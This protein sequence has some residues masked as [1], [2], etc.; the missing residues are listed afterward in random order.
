MNRLENVPSTSKADPM[1]P[2]LIGLNDGKAGMKGLDKEKINAIIEE[3]SRNSPFY[4]H[5]QRKEARI[6][7]Q[8]DKMLRKWA[9]VT[10][11]QK[12]A[13]LRIMMRD[14]VEYEKRAKDL[15]QIICHVDMDMFFAA[16][17]MKDQPHLREKPIAVGSMSMI[18]T[19]NYVAR[20][21]G[22]RAAMAG[23]IAKKLCPDLILI[24]CNFQKYSKES[25]KIMSVLRQYDPNILIMSCDEA[26]L[27]LTSYVVESFLTKPENK[28]KI[29]L[30]ENEWTNEKI[31][32][33]EVW[34]HASIIVEEMRGRVFQSSQLTCSA[35]IS[36]NTMLAKIASDMNKPD[37]QFM[38]P[39]LSYDQIQEFVSKIDV[40]KIPGIGP[41]QEKVLKAFN[42][43]TC[44]DLWDHRD[45]IYIL[46]ENKPS[47]INFYLRVSLGLG[48]SSTAKEEEEP[49]KSKGTENTFKPT[50][51]FT[52]LCNELRDMSQEISDSLNDYGLKGKTIT[53][54]LKKDSFDVI[55]KSRSLQTVTADANV[56]FQ[57]A[58]NIL[59][60]EIET[61][62]D[63]YRL[64]GVR[65]SHLIEP[66]KD[67]KE[68]SQQ[69]TLDKFFSKNSLV[70]QPKRQKVEEPKCSPISMM[71]VKDEENKDIEVMDDFFNETDSEE[72]ICPCGNSFEEYKTFETHMENCPNTSYS[73]NRDENQMECPVCKAKYFSKLDE[74]NSHLDEC[75]KMFGT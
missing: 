1:K 45:L 55:V 62:N 10:E 11:S 67:Q 12:E 53:L 16:V 28:N 40:R 33:P 21:Y 41:V 75:L 44:K 35:G 23:F 26:Y 29:V 34:D 64:M 52:W 3:A 61:T 13:A 51:D 74:L 54:K 31:L 22:V 17:E 66:N 27:N 39:G 36:T 72:Y 48:S 2:S 18:S 68:S 24:K 42:L 32:I 14:R 69:Q 59:R 49:R 46:F 7:A 63:K 50:N 5:V 25:E 30:K 8:V 56:I 58:R 15:S 70:H 37:G 71:K 43:K 73:S 20:R 19:S 9:A 60:N 6:N 47:S 57:T 4:K 65:V 38:L